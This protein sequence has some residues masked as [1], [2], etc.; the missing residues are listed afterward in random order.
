M[1]SFVP[2]Y[3]SI[4]DKL[5]RKV[6]YSKVPAFMMEELSDLLAEL[7]TDGISFSVVCI[8][9]FHCIHCVSKFH[10]GL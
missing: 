8:S 4:Q 9:I 1:V 7:F 3:T 2:F 6:I 5:T 10:F